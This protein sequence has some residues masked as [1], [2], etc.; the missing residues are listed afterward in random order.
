MSTS[1]TMH[2]PHTSVDIVGA[3]SSTRVLSIDIFRGLNI[4]LMI[5]VNELASVRDLPWW[6]LSRQ[7]PLG[8]H[9]LRRHGLPRLS[10]SSACRS[11]S[12]STSA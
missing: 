10:S 8:R 7:D 4:A 1:T 5:F 9:D 2:A 6:D 11:R 12:P 3:P